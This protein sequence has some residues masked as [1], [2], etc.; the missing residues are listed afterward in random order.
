MITIISA[1]FSSVIS[2]KLV[3]TS[4]SRPLPRV[5]RRRGGDAISSSSTD[6]DLA[7]ILLLVAAVI[8]Y[9]LYLDIFFE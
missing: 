3:G 6:K 1:G 4:A 7:L 8:A 9:Y 2:D 5:L